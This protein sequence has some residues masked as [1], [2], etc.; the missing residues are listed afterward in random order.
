MRLVAAAASAVAGLVLLGLGV[1]FLLGADGQPHRLVI[2]ALGT[3]LGLAALST[4][5]WL[6][7]RG[8]ILSP[9]RLRGEIL[10]LARA[11]DGEIAWSDV[12]A[13]LGDRAAA[14]REV[15]GRLLLDGTCERGE[16][17]GDEVFRFPALRPRLVR[18]RCT[19]CGY[20]AALASDL[21]GCPRCGAALVVRREA[22][23]V[24]EG[25]YGM[26]D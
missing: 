13:G 26:D 16:A 11:R 6:A 17:D 1:L 20:E 10:A 7:W 19:H 12:E 14:G 22:V 3:G 25:L 5:A 23:D 2:A 18:R 24:E 9:A 21:E 15:L 8:L 4:G